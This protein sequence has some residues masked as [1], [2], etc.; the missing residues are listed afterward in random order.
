MVHTISTWFNHWTASGVSMGTL[1]VN[2]DEPRWDQRTIIGRAKHFFAI[3]NPL[4]ILATDK[5]LQ[6][7]KT[8]VDQYRRGEIPDDLSKDALWK[9]K[10]LVDSAY[11]PDTGEKNFLIGRMSFQVPGNMIITGCMMTF[12]RSTPSVIFWQV[13]RSHN[14][15]SIRGIANT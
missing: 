10:H 9:A 4:N 15:L 3:T 8:L 11:H 12:Y 7:A 2:L 14:I 6:A 13:I 5:E 1:R